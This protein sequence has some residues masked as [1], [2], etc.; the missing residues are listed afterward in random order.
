MPY[1][2]VPKCV[3][4]LQIEHAL[5]LD[6]LL[7]L[8]VK[9]DGPLLTKVGRNALPNAT[10]HVLII[11]SPKIDL[12][13][14]LSGNNDFQAQCFNVLAAAETVCTDTDR[15]CCARWALCNKM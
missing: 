15:W 7:G 13:K 11:L 12:L 1:I 4:L 2:L 6:R 14:G 10:P 3:L 8:S 5:I 9:F